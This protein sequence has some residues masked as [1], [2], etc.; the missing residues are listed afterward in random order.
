MFSIFDDPTQSELGSG[1][2]EAPS[3]A[4]AIELIGDTRAN[5][6][7]VPDRAGWCGDESKLLWA[8]D[9]RN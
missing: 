3:V 1:Y 2:V 7:P 8:A 6:Y 4:E 5:L 9:E